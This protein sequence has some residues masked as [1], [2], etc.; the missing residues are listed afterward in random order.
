VDASAWYQKVAVAILIVGG[1]MS[2]KYQIDSLVNEVEKLKANSVQQV[3]MNEF[4]VNQN[5]EN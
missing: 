2:H 1:F 3:Q 4:T 5:T